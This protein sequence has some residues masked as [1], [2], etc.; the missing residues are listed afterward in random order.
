MSAIDD[1]MSVKLYNE[2]VIMRVL[3]HF[4]VSNY[5]PV[6][7]PIPSSINLKIPDELAMYRTLY[8]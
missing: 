1:G 8:W 7:T 6:N 2:P 4:N 3:D 5:K